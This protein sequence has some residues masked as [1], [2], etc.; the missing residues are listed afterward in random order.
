VPPATDRTPE[1]TALRVTLSTGAATGTV[2]VGP[3][4]SEN[5][6]GARRWQR[7][8]P[9]S[10][11]ARVTEKFRHDSEVTAVSHQRTRMPSTRDSGTPHA[12]TIAA[13]KRRA[14]TNTAV[15][16]A[17]PEGRQGVRF[18][19]TDIFGYSSLP[20]SGTAP[21]TWLYRMFDTHGDLL[22]IG[23]SGAL[24]ARMDLHRT[25]KPWWPEV[26]HVIATMIGQ[27]HTALDLERATI[28]AEM[29]RHNKRSKPGAVVKA[30]A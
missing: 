21:G 14:R 23:I 7:P 29:P 16:V 26:D 13:A 2:P 17:L 19:A 27:E 28:R 9:F 11:H 6:E 5:A 1:P 12:Q 25:G 10:R 20:W 18:Q 8:G 3:S 24:G 22:Y 15:R 30:V 4:A